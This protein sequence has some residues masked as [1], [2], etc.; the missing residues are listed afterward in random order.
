MRVGDRVVK[1]PA[2]RRPGTFDDWGR[3]VGVVVEPPFDMGVD[4]RW[5]VLRARGPAVAGARL[6]PKR[7]VDNKFEIRVDRQFVNSFNRRLIWRVHGD[8]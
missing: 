6:G 2:T 5:P 4:V 7:G 3:G 8:R 1:N